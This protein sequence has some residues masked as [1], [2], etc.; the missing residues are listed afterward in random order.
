VRR[1][2][3][4]AGGGVIKLPEGEVG[5]VAAALV[6]QFHSC[7][8]AGVKTPLAVPPP[9]Y[10]AACTLSPPKSYICTEPVHDV[11][12]AAK[13]DLVT[14]GY[15]SPKSGEIVLKVEA[16]K[17]AP[18]TAWARRM[19]EM[20]RHEMTHAADPYV[21]VRRKPYAKPV[22]DKD[23]CKYVRD[24]A[25]VAANMAEVQEELLNASRRHDIE[26]QTRKGHIEQPWEILHIS[27]TYLRVLT[28][29]TPKLKRRFYQMAARMWASGKLGPLPRR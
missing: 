10:Q 27:P 24:P 26:W 14:G 11:H 16:G 9:D 7:T 17:C 4:L 22:T 1:K 8:P 19:R 20:L 21:H 12:W 23:Y 29:L 5:R 15:Y 2:R 25:E 13:G 18:R 28:C 6:K 3:T